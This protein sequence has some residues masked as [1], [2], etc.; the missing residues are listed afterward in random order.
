MN[1][2]PAEDTPLL[3]EQ[4]WAVK[5]AAQT[6]RDHGLQSIFIQDIC[7][8]FTVDDPRKLAFA[9]SVLLYLRETIQRDRYVN[10]EPY[11]RWS[12]EQTKN[13]DIVTIEETI[14][15]L[16]DLFLD[17]PRDFQTIEK[18]LWYTFPIEEQKA[19]TLRVVN[20]LTSFEAPEGLVG[21]PVTA[22][23]LGRVWRKGRT[24]HVPSTNRSLVE[25][26]D[27]CL[28]PRVIHL[29]DVI[30]DF[31][32]LAL[33][34][35]TLNNPPMMPQ[36]FTVQEIILLIFSAGGLFRF[37]SAHK[38]SYGLTVLAFISSIAAS[39][40]PG[41]TS[42]LLLTLSM[43]VHVVELHLAKYPS[44]V[45]LLPADMCL[46]LAVYLQ[47]KLAQGLI[48]VVLYLSPVFLFSAYLL[49]LS[50]ADTFS[51]LTGHGLFIPAPME[52]RVAYLI[53]AVLVAIFAVTCGSILTCLESRDP[54]ANRWD[55]Y[56]SSAGHEART[57]WFRTIVVYS[58]PNLYPSPLSFLHILPSLDVVK[59][60]EKLICRVVV[61]P[62]A[63]V[64]SKR[65]RA[66]PA[67]GA[68]SEADLSSLHD[69]PSA[70]A[71]STRRV[72]PAS[73]PSL[74]TLCAQRFAANFVKL[75]N[76]EILWQRLSE[77]LQFLP[78]TLV[79]KLFK[80]LKATCPT[81]L[82]HEFI[83][84]F[85]L[86]GRAI[87]LTDALPGVN[88]RTIGDIPRINNRVRE[89]EIIGFGR[90]SDHA[91][92]SALQHL[93][94]LRV[95]ILRGCSMV[96]T[97]AVS[98]IASFCP[99]LK[100]VNLNY[101][102][103]NPASVARLVTSCTH[104]ESLKVAGIQNW[105]DATFLN[106]LNGLDQDTKLTDLRVLKLRQTQLGDSSIHA[107][108][109]LCPGL[110]SLDV[111]FT[112]LKRP[113]SLLSPLHI[114][115]LEKLSLT[116]T[117][118]LPHQ[119]ASILPLYPN[120]RILLLGALGISRGTQASISNTSAMTLD[121]AGLKLVTNALAGF[122]HLE[123]VNLAGNAKLGT[124]TKFDP[125]ILDFVSRV[126]RKCRRLNLAG[127]SNL[128]STDLAGL[129]NNG[130]NAAVETLV[131]NN[132]GVDDEAG[133]YISACK[134][135]R[136]L[137]VAG[138]RFTRGGLFPVIDGCAELT[139]CRGIN[140][141]DRRRFFEIWEEQRCQ[142]ADANRQSS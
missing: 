82:K 25:R 43:G 33:L 61:G 141:V 50:V 99:D 2:H 17:S 126:G 109:N 53:F 11:E 56:S 96:G 20:F 46:P 124:T 119:L 86:R 34:I 52:T 100:V 58:N 59:R 137:A 138:T 55:R 69:V 105:T 57:S 104:L 5:P 112:L 37:R 45:Y 38:L 83:V 120:L 107:L 27:A 115:P 63:L 76:N 116:S 95:L 88:A 26:Y 35:Y 9:F 123:H 8:A 127:I 32:Y 125:A 47:R 80:M 41:Q 13:T 90:I 71:S 134:H 18:V 114:L 36:A 142:Q 102:S 40:R 29:L 16:W 70:A 73:V 139:S 74:T 39:P 121:D 140:V 136:T 31:A 23:S 130:D 66:L 133:I 22:W 111:S 79:P 122:L 97:K 89:L 7:P 110:Q 68:P 12:Q 93:T 101:T 30:S 21:H 65:Q 78:E 128:Q 77:Q 132:T 28:T 15:E 108:V 24:I 135:L 42:F 62:F 67:F 85:M 98:A 118:I 64:V 103:A 75:R 81:Y 117:S 106:F 60:A 48:P 91:F 54:A 92:A 4:S 129:L 1:R 19:K 44:P 87:S 10:K 51:W 94:D 113:A 6:L 84:T 14:K 72:P 3:S 131:L 49:S